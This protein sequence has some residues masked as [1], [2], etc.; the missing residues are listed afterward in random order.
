[1]FFIWGIYMDSL[2]NSLSK[3]FTTYNSK[4]NIKKL[5]SMFK[6]TPDNYDSLIYSIYEL[7][8]DGKILG[9]DDGNYTHISPD[10]YL[11]QGII[12]KSSKN[13][14]YINLGSGVI[15]NIPNK[16][17]NGAKENDLVFVSL[18]KGEKHI[19]QRIGSVVRIVEP[20]IIQDMQSFT[21]AIIKK[22]Y[23]R[24]YYYIRVNDSVIY[25]PEKE[26]NKAYPGDL[27]TVQITD[28]KM[29]K[30]IDIIKRN[31]SEHVFE[32][33]E[34]N[35]EKRFTPIGTAHFDIDL[36]ID[37][38]FEI[39]DRIL[40]D[41][42][43]ENKVTFIK[44]MDK[45]N[46]LNSYIKALFC[47]S[48]FNYEFS[49]KA[50]KE[51]ES[52][53]STIT[54]EDLLE[55]VDLRNLETITIDGCRA[56]D[57]D[58]AISLE[59]KDNKYYLYVHIADVTH[60][61]K[62]GSS[63][64]NDA[65]RKS[66]SVYPANTVFPMLP[67][68]L[69]NGVCSLNPNED[70][71]T[72]T[73]KIEFDL[74]GNVLDFEV[75]NSVINRNKRMTYGCVNN[76]LTNN[77]VDPDYVSY[78]ETL[79]LMNELSN[80]LQQKKI[81]RGFIFFD[82]V[83]KEFEFDEHGEIENIN[84]YHRGPAE[85]LIENFMLITNELVTSLAYYYQLPFAYRN[86]EGPTIDQISKLRS[87]LKEYKK[88]V[89][90]IKNISN[91][92]I[93]QKILLNLCKGKEDTEATYFSN[94]VLRCM[95]RAFYASTNFGHYALAL[96]Y[97]G[98]FTSP[99]RRFP[100]LLNHLMIEKMINGDLWNL[101]SYREEYKEMCGYCTEMQVATEKFEL[102]I[103]DMLMKKYISKFIG[104]E[105]EAKIEFISHHVIGI[106]TTNNIC[107]YIELP[108]NSFDGN[109]V[110]INETI[111]EVGDKI[112]VTLDGIKPNSDETLFTIKEKIKI[113]SKRKKV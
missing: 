18:K 76:I 19:K 83:S 79:K 63:L 32:Y 1:M 27:V 110:T 39:G 98:T 53:S 11:K 31:N 85:Y 105:L 65:Y 97:Y 25:I 56:K 50:L 9:D 72:K 68:E 92:K 30:V 94:M 109:K 87:N 28:N 48:G 45:A 64:F 82:S 3:F 13:K 33:K 17:L 101:D 70:K 81:E 91:P 14:F 103:E 29:A 41:L 52:I 62:Y 93:L 89:N 95:N 77:I 80:L 47:D 104:Q 69:S 57:L 4:I 106:K 24:N 59:F 10:Y 26:L 112:K 46:G 12:Q 38:F 42:D 40:V 100:D 75:F 37:A 43:L 16:N 44:K 71:L 108:K 15:I 21:K 36:K 5:I 107:G 78:V 66:T 111:Y 96:D 20:P 74:E 23:T 35:G 113:L 88:F 34:I 67:K 2:K 51:V 86:H 61:V 54:K 58:D 84:D 90:T 22:N 49:E 60:Y 6:V 102:H 99:I 7:E 73:C 55:R 8:K